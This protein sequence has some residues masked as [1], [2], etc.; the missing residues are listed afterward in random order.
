VP[1]SGPQNQHFNPLNTELNPICHLLALLG[2]HPVLHVSRIRVNPYNYIELPSITVHKT[3]C[4]SKH[5]WQWVVS[6]HGGS[7]E[8]TCRRG[9]V[10]HIFSGL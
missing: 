6:N 5:F 8:A 3:T 1:L 4:I 7:T 10:L 9:R 2:A